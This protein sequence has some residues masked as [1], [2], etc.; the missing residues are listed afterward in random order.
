[1]IKNPSQDCFDDALIS[2][3]VKFQSI[4]SVIGYEQT[5]A[6]LS[7]ALVCHVTK[8]NLNKSLKRN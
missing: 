4:F 3:L 8:V 7:L 2:V 1:M 6:S 5:S